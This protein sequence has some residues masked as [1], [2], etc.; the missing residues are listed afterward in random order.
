MS[1][2]IKRSRVML[3]SRF[4]LPKALNPSW[5]N[6]T[7]GE[8]WKSLSR[9]SILFLFSFLS[10]C[11]SDKGKNIPDVS[12]I[13]IGLAVKHFE[14]DLLAL[15]TSDLH[16]A[17]KKLEADYPVFIKELYMGR[18]LPVLQDSTIFEAFVKS[19]GIRQL[20]DTVGL[21]YGDFKKEKAELEDAFRFYKH[22]FPERELPTVITFVSEYTIGV[23]TYE[24]I[25]GIGLD[26]FLGE[27]NPHYDP[28]VFPKYIRRTMNRE[29]LVSRAMEAV[30]NDLVGDA[31]GEKLL[32]IMINNGKVLYVLDCL[33]PHTPDS[34]K[35]GYTAAQTEWVE[36][37]ELQMWT[38][39]M[40]EE[41]LYETNLRD[42]RKL[43]DHSPG[44]PGMPHE[45]PGRTAN[46]TGWQI[47]KAYMKRQPETTLM[48]LIEITDAQEIL[49]K[50]KYKPR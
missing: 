14:L 30:A 19:E 44:S 50:A 12:N 5:I 49:N 41:L 32:D 28:N 36:G 48:Q 34:I 29:H 46:W 16:T 38:H 3:P 13:E 17:K 7:C 22:Y 42:I 10:A 45:A 25:L 4:C 27:N 15:D 11:T 35:L 39:F 2:N 37:N 23:F 9:F 24:G 47:V 43:V 20:I 31:R 26:F 6:V 8:N 1:Q 21:V 18:I 33:L 40:G